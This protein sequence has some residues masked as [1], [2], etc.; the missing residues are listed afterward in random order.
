MKGKRVHGRDEIDSYSLKISAPL[1]EDSLLHLV[2]LS[3]ENQNFAAPWKPQLVRKRNYKNFDIGSFL[4]DINKSDLNTIVTAAETLDSAANA[5]EN[6][7]RSIL[8]HHAPMKTFHMRRNY[9]PRISE[10]TK[11]LIRNRNAL[12]EEATRTKCGILMKEFNLLSKEVKKAVAK[13]EKEFFERGFDDGM[14]STKAWRTANELLGTVKKLSPT[15][16]VHQK[17][18]D[19]SPEMVTNPLKMADIF[20]KDFKRKITLLRQKTATAAVIEPATRLAQ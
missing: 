2:N 13:E 6:I 3:I 19:E 17:D 7:F 16:I 18:G 11:D 20:N 10:A 15:A 1:I 9:N 12:Q 8:N 5:F 4:T 14:D